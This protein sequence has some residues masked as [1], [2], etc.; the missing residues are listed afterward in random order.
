MDNYK[1]AS[2]PG[3]GNTSTISYRA[4]DLLT[5]VHSRPAVILSL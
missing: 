5:L 3:K 2:D 4:R 1:G